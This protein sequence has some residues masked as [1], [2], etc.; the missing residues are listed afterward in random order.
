MPSIMFESGSTGGTTPSWQSYTG[1]DGPGIYIDVPVQ[2]TSPPLP[3]TPT[4]SPTLHG[5]QA[6]WV[7][8]GVTSIYNATPTGFRIYLRR[9]DGGPLTPADAVN[10]D[11][12][13]VWTAAL[14]I[15]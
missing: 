15:Q 5:T 11:W 2:S 3:Y 13:I 9:S 10:N 1:P 12:S 6:Q 7:V 8:T 4:Y 14:T